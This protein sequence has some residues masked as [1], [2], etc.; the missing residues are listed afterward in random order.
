M[1]AS[2]C[3]LVRCFS[4][5]GVMFAVCLTLG[6]VASSCAEEQRSTTRGTS[7]APSASAADAAAA[8]KVREALFYQDE[9]FVES[10]HRRDPFRAYTA[11]FRAKAPEDMQRRVVMPTT[12]VEE[13]RLIALVTGTARPKAMLLDP[14]GVGHVVERGDYLGRAKVIQATG[15]VSM[16]INWRVDRIR[17]NEVVLT[18]QDPADPSRVA[19]TKILPLNEEVAAR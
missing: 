13:M 5:C 1:S 6:I 10:P 7:G 12:S 16:T 9:D 15:N 17:E 2:D 18:Q 4:R 8:K 14:A 11:T 3:E 19:L